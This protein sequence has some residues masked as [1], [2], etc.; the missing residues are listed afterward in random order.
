MTGK[1]KFWLPA[2]QSLLA[3]ALL[4]ISILWIRALEERS[5][6]MVGSV[7]T[8]DF[9]VSLNAP[10]AILRA[11]WFRYLPDWWDYALFVVA[12]AV[13]WYW[14]ALN[15]LSWQKTRTTRSFSWM[16]LRAVAD[17]CLVGLGIFLG[18]AF[19][20][21]F[22]W[23]IV[24]FGQPI[25]VMYRGLWGWKDHAVAALITSPFAIWSLLLIVL[26]ARDLY[27]VFSHAWS[28]RGAVRLDPCPK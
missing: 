6:G 28:N 18:L 24:I 10:V 4:C 20:T 14:V 15:I 26:F 12:V 17:L 3:I 9:L 13:F 1:L 19:A 21:N 25:P 16:P 2:G 22:Y 11:Y 8:F 23:P 7:P 5:H 27:Y